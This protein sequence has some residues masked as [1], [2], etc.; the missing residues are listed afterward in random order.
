MSSTIYIKTSAYRVWRSPRQEEEA[1]PEEVCCLFVSFRE[2]DSQLVAEA[3]HHG[4]D[5]GDGR[6]ERSHPE[7]R[8]DVE[9]GE[10]GGGEDRQGLGEDGAAD[11]LEDIKDEG[12][13]RIF[14]NPN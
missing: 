6:E 8:R 1:Q 11:E 9:A 13:C 4:D 7:G 10:D 14:N 2:H 12:V 5:A 3:G